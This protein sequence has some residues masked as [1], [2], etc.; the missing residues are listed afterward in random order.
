M[1]IHDSKNDSNIRKNEFYET[2]IE[3]LIMENWQPVSFQERKAFLL[4]FSGRDLAY[5]AEQY[6]TLSD[7]LRWFYD[8][9]IK[10]QS[11]KK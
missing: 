11:E 3:K 7:V 6:D 9:I 4:G 1:K 10:I 2:I 8:T 5:V